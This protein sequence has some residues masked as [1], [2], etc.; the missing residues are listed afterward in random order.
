MS[1]DDPANA[2]FLHDQRDWPGRAPRN[3]SYP[4]S[5]RKK[6]ISWR[7]PVALQLGPPAEAAS[8]L[9]AV[10]LFERDY[11]SLWIGVKVHLLAVLDAFAFIDRHRRRVR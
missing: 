2:C 1:N 4:P 11:A 3:G 10:E 6:A 7:S 5:L 8:S 9:L